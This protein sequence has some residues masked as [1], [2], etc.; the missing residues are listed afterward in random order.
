MR[1]LLAPL[2][3]LVPL[4][5]F[6]IVAGC[7]LAL[8]SGCVQ[9]ADTILEPDPGDAAADRGPDAMVEAQ[10]PM[11]AVEPAALA[12]AGAGDVAEVTIRSVGDAPLTIAR[13][14]RRGPPDFS[15]VHA[16]GNALLQG[17]AELS[18][19]DGL[20]P[21]EAIV[22]TVEA[23]SGPPASAV[24]L[25]ETDDPARPLV[26]VPLGFP[27]APCLRAA[28]MAVDFGDVPLGS[29]VS[30]Q[31]D[32]TNCG[33]GPVE[34]GRL[35]LREG[36][37]A[38][39]EL[40][41]PGPLLGTVEPGE[42]LSVTVTYTAAI[43]APVNGTLLIEAGALVLGVPLLARGLGA[44]CPVAI[45][46]ADELRA[47]VGDAVVLD[48]SGSIDRDGPGGRPLSWQWV[49][50]GR[51]NGS[52]A[53]PV[54]RLH[55]PAQ[56]DGGGLDD[57]PATPTAVM[58]LDRPGVFVFELQ[59]ADAACADVTRVVI[60][61]CPCEGQGIRVLL[62]WH[63]AADAPVGAGIDLDLHLLHPNAE[64]WF[65]RP[66]D[67]HYA[68]P[69]P[70]WGQLDNDIDDPRLS[71]DATGAGPEEIVLRRPEGTE[72]LGAPYLV[73]V[74]HR[75]IAP[76]SGD[77][78]WPEQADAALRIYVDDAL[79]LESTRALH[80]DALW[81][82]AEIHWPSGEVIVRDRVYDQRP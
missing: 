75:G 40:G 19:P 29:V 21:G 54:E 57:D 31:V 52:T 35:E 26:E 70:D 33:M 60:E 39:F 79:V 25:I 48:G 4:Y 23:L 34:I 15:L 56:P 45:V 55:D 1:C 49:V 10:A 62:D 5:R 43:E 37:D 68:E 76:G 67:C 44:Q 12:F 80:A 64:N 74:H 38:Q 53:T 61:V 66:Y 78:P 6:T 14:G 8:A 17:P 63:S 82:A 58:F 18:G 72:L 20:A 24:L 2:C 47:E 13:I 41:G 81:D 11:V 9:D 65:S 50:V 32:I 28:P 77:G 30:R 69:V 3:L 27:D 42:A 71:V 7:A 59:V 36:S 51:P 22:L 73:G 16:G 46:P